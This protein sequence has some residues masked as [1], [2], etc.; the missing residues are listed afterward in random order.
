MDSMLDRIQEVEKERQRLRLGGGQGEIEKQHQKG[1]LTARERIE[2]LLDP[3]T[4]HELELWA[5]ATRTGF[6]VDEREL[7]ADAVAIGYG[8]VGGRPILVYAHDF[9]VSGG[10]QAAVQ[11]SKVTKV[12]DTAVKMGIP[13]VGI[14]DSGGIRVQDLQGLSGWRAPIGGF[15]LGDSGSFMFSPP[16]ASGVVPQIALMLGPNYAG[17]SY[18]P[19]MADFLIMRRGPAYMSL[20]SPS[21]MK[22]VTF[23]D[24]TQEEVGGALLHAEVSGINDLMV[25][26]DEEGIEVCRKLLGFFPLNNRQKPPVVKI[27]DPPERKNEALVDLIPVDP[28]QE[29]NMREVISEIVDSGDFFEIKPLY[30]KNVIIGFAR[31]DGQTV[32]LVAN[33]PMVMGG[34]ID[35][36]SSDKEARF[37]RFCDAF[38]IPLVFL[39]DTLGYLPSEEQEQLGLER[40][41]AKVMYA[42]CEATVPKITLHLRN[43]SGWGEL[44]M[45]T[46]QMGVDIVL[47]LPTAKVGQM[48]PE[49]AVNVIYRKEIEAASN[50]EEVRQRRMKEFSEQ[51]NN[52]FHAGARQLVHDIIDPRDTRATLITA[53]GWLADKRED[54]PWKKHGN[55][56]L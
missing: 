26:S 16:W 6:D 34:T 48:D 45:G 39:V 9:T 13:Y 38:N 20:V 44:A 22:E 24:V 32:G 33:D 25:E 4:F 43:C 11:H 27:G 54:R 8:E 35:R 40:H 47:A 21:V 17:S 14:V 31:L 36:N 7:P 49:A 23:V 19:I 1:K 2:K 3:G 42:I 29:Y 37:I 55:I 41:A 51:Y 18:S 52:L 10:T 53:L 28:S 50:P 30:A 12:M 56:P 15:G 46:E 5:K